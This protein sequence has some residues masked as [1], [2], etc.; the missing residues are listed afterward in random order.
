M[1]KNI[2]NKL[3]LIYLNNDEHTHMDR[4]HGSTDTLDMFMFISPNLAIHDIFTY[5]LKSQ[6][7]QHRIGIHLLTPPN[8]NLN[9]MTEKYSNLH[10]IRR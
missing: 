3:D 1:L 10:S 4:A 7:S 9:R 5:P 8:T 2:Q 6:S